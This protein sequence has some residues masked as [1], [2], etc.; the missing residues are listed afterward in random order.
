MI[1]DNGIHVKASIYYW[2]LVAIL[3]ENKLFGL[4]NVARRIEKEYAETHG[5]MSQILV[6][7]GLK[8]NHTIV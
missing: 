2:E 8:L 1:F 5:I 3:W 7:C 6:I 4:S